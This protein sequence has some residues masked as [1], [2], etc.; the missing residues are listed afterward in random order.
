MS[1]TKKTIK[2]FL[3]LSFLNCE[4]QARELYQPG[5][6]SRCQAMGGVCI[7][8]VRGAQA[9]FLNPAFLNKVEGFDFIIAQTQFGISKDT[10]DFTSQF[11]GS[12]FQNSDINNLY[13][14][15]LAADI[16]ARSGIVMPN[17]GFGV[18]SNNYTQMQFNDPTYP[19]FEMNFIA[20]YGY[21][22]GAAFAAGSSTSVG[23]TFRH[24]KRW[25]GSEEINVGSLIG[26][27][28]N[29]VANSNFQDKGVGHA[30]DIGLAHTMDSGQ[31]KTIFA[32]V[33]RDVGVT[34][35]NMTSGAGDPPRQLDNLMLGVSITQDISFIKFSHGFEYKFAT[36]Y[37]ENPSK[38]IHLGTEASLGP[39]DLRAG[40]SQ[41]YVTYGVGLD[42]WFFNVEATSYSTELGT[43]AGQDRS[44]RYNVSINF[45]MDFDQ[46]FK[47]L[48]SDGK[49]RR[50]MQR[51]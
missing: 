30:L 16:D 37:A 3:F 46:S 33:W 27:S 17:F 42:L 4:V 2:I 24:I 21:V 8:Q 1:I 29:D 15:Y 50:L 38:K 40:L 7:A 51:R 45:E 25:G 34:K 31:N 5:L 20:D 12:S 14:K 9:L 13:G 48:G 18:Y 35:F 43:Y 36:E 41:G 11:S 26:S 47:L 39:L 44:E 22:V 6:P 49:K 19:T 28:A 10:V 32:L 23:L